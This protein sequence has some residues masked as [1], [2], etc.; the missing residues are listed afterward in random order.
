M[1]ELISTI[2]YLICLKQLDSSIQKSIFEG[3]MKSTKQILSTAI[4]L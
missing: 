2:F 3:S 4:R 1:K